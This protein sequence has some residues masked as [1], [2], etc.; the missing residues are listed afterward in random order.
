MAHQGQENLKIEAVLSYLLTNSSSDASARVLVCDS[1]NYVVDSLITRIH[2]RFLKGLRRRPNVVRLG[3]NFSNIVSRTLALD[4][5]AIREIASYYLQRPILPARKAAIDSAD[6]VFSTNTSISSL[7]IAG[8]IA[9]FNV[10]LVDEAAA[11][12]LPSALIP[13]VVAS[14]NIGTQPTWA[15]F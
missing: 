9:P 2:H 1:E 15:L 3:T 10:I 7:G 6:I 14:K 4:K 13:I 12:T 8:I 5:L 11:C